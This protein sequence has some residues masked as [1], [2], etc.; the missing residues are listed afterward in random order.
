MISMFQMLQVTMGTRARSS[1]VNTIRSLPYS[2]LP[3]K[4]YEV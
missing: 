3:S 4:M 2:M 1:N